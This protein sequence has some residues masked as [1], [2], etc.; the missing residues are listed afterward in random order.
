MYTYDTKLALRTNSTTLCET[1][2]CS[3]FLCFLC[4]RWVISEVEFNNRAMC[5]KILKEIAQIVP[6]SPFQYLIAA[7]MLKH[8]ALSDNGKTTVFCFY[9]EGATVFY[10]YLYCLDEGEECDHVCCERQLRKLK[11]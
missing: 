4:H 7:K 6:R 5:D 8:S 3:F 1:L 9:K 10:W 11:T 2:I